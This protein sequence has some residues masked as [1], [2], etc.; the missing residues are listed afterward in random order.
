VI[1]DTT[2]REA[3]DL[4]RELRQRVEAAGFSMADAK[5]LIK[6]VHGRGYALGIVPERIA[7]LD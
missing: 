3:K 5:R 7:V 6:A 1:E 4:I 2:G